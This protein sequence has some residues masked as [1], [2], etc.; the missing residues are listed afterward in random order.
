MYKHAKSS[1]ATLKN[2]KDCL[3]WF[4]HTQRK[5][6]KKVKMVQYYICRIYKND[7][8]QILQ[9]NFLYRGFIEVFFY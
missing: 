6:W 1:K 5:K 2:R 3:R 7:L 9:H 4:L 8:N